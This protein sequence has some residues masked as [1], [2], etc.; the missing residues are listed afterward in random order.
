M[1]KKSLLTLLPIAALAIGWY[2]VQSKNTATDNPSGNIT[3]SSSDHSTPATSASQTTAEENPFKAEEDPATVIVESINNDSSINSDPSKTDNSNELTADSP[4]TTTASDIETA[5]VAIEPLS[6]AE[7][8]RLAGLL[9]NDKQLRL[10]LLEEFRNNNDPVRAKKLAAL[11]GPYDDTEI[12][13]V[14]SELA[15]SGDTQSR[16]AGLDLLS[17]IQ[18]RSNEARDIAIGLLGAGDNTEILVAT[19]N[20]LATP[21]PN[22]SDSQRQNLN[23]NLNNLSRHYDSKVRSHSISL[24]ARWD[25]N[26]SVA[27]DAFSR[28]LTDKDPAVRSSATFAINNINNPDAAMVTGLLSIAENTNEKRTTRYAALRALKNMPLTGTQKRRHALAQRSANS[29]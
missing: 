2:V 8:I 27:R 14:A 7:F 9:Q 3:S 17:R 19:M 28:G 25:K 24:L 11:L 16:I 4:A 13:E 15:Y 12:L 29:R 10:S 26:S 5:S 1:I 18:P 21:P 23:D 6:D 22:A 20:V